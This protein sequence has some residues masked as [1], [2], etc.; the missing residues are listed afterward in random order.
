MNI[1]LKEIKVSDIMID[2]ADNQEAGVIGYGKKLNIRP[3]YQREFIYKEEQRNRVIETIFKGFPLNI[4]YWAKNGEEYEL[5]DGQQR[6]LSVCQYVNGDFSYDNRFFHNLTKEEQQQILDYKLM[7]YVCEGT[8]KE[9]LDWF[10]I[11]NISGEELT[12]QEL[13]NAVY[14]GKWLSD[15]KKYFSKTGCP[16]YAI[17]SNYMS[18]TPIRQDYLETAINWISNGKIEEYMAKH[19]HAK[20]ANELWLY[21]QSVI[22]WVK[23]VFPKCRKE[24]KGL[25]WGPLY[26][27]YKDKQFDSEKLEERLVELFMDDDVTSKKGAYLYLIDGK[28]KHLSIRAFT[29]AMKRSAYEKQKGICKK[30]GK[31][32]EISEMEAD[33]I[34]PWSQG[35]KTNVE[36]CQMLCKNC[37]RTKSSK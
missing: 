6:T 2:Y 37:N 15:A 12:Q 4:M 19:Q 31:T 14:T 28:E 3:P 21:F 20:N 36:N 17:S 11:I 22:N 18:G 26:N 32:F 30:C 1:V 33:H 23:V 16:A 25:A 5:M 9:K 24:M 10:K 29:P 8:E 35:G 34:T 13:R 7:I 27:Q